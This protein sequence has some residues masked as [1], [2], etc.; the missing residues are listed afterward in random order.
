METIAIIPAYNEEKNIGHVLS[1]LK[2]VALIKKVIVVSDGSTDDTVNV[3]RS[4]GVEIIE[5]MENRGKGGAL[6]AG[7]DNFQADVVLF[8][9][10][11]LLGLTEKHVLNLVEPVINDEADMTIGIFEKGRIATDLAQKMAPYLSGQRA[12]KFSLLEKI[13]DLDV[14]RF[15][16]ELAL[17]RFMESSNI[18]VKEVLL[19]DMSH[20]MKEEKMGVWKGMAA[21]M[22]MYWEIIKYL[23]RV[24]T[25][26]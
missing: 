12:L 22:K 14:A 11:D 23:T 25:L 10:A 13:S 7:L 17:N 21:R 9:D 16:V 6:K 19:Y 5:L 8:L 15:G 1:V 4:Y 18:R 20:V 3:A 2:D 24:K 26:R